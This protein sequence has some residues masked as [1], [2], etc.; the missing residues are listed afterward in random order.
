MLLIDKHLL[1]VVPQCGFS[2][3]GIVNTTVTQGRH[4]QSGW[5]RKRRTTFRSSAQRQTVGTQGSDYHRIAHAQ[6]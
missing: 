5:S 4:R 2:E 3:T 6:L 1:S